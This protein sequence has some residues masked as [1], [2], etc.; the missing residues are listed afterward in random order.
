MWIVASDFD[1]TLSHESDKFVIRKDIAEKINSF[2]KIYK[3]FVV[4]GREE[5]Y[6]K[7]LA[8]GL[9]PTGWIL[10]NGSL[11]V[12]NSKKIINAPKNWFTIRQSI[13]RKL[14]EL[15]IPHSFG[16]VIIYVDSWSEEISFESA[17]VERNRRDA[18]I[19]PPNVEK[20]SGL[21][22]AL[23]ELNVEGKV[24]AVGD[25]ENDVSL[26]RVADYKVAVENALP[27]IK[28]LAD[29]VLDKEDGD[30]VVELLDLILSGRFPEGVNIH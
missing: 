28:S 8:P 12:V 6:M 20:G 21:R 30:G 5:R 24:V 29:F 7:L 18:M 4:T 22:I 27:E 3:F 16:E 14:K 17:R 26:F 15:G 1:R 13:S 9:S 19:L 10:E 2:S 23:K 11:I 25:A